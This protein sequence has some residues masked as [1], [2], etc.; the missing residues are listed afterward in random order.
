MIMS[1]NTDFQALTVVSPAAYGSEDKNQ[2]RARW[3]GTVAVA[4]VCDGVSS[5]SASADAASYVSDSAPV[6][7]QGDVQDRLGMLCDGL[8]IRRL[9]AQKRPVVI[10][11]GTSP[12]MREL[13]A[14]V[15]RERLG[16]AF[17]TT[18][19]TASFT[20]IEHGIRA[21]IIRCGDSALFA[22]SG[23]GDLLSSSP[24]WTRARREPPPDPALDGQIRFGPGDELSIRVLGRA[25]ELAPPVD[26]GSSCPKKSSDWLVCV[27]GDSEGQRTHV[28][29]ER[30]EVPAL[31]ISSGDLLLV[32]ASFLKGSTYRG[33]NCNRR[34]RFSPAIRRAGRRLPPLSN[35]SF[36]EKGVVTNVLPDHY[37]AGRWVH[38]QDLFPPNTHF[39]LASDGFYSAFE[40]PTELWTWLSKNKARLLHL[41]RQRKLMQG[42]HARLSRKS[43]DD[44]MSFVWVSPREPVKRP[45]ANASQP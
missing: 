40:G 42:L 24:L 41:D 13:L 19:I 11:L 2:D 25:S 23:S 30:G 36:R 10:R 3:F 39:V 1:E 16:S 43:G 8:F 7:F 29:P 34:L 5:S 12:A 4:A 44:D 33:Q 35:I 14:A 37:A 26:V 45:L 28:S 6:L 21:E 27:P 32:P 22:F 20:K 18:L 17:Q 38:R 9:E 31:T 15:A